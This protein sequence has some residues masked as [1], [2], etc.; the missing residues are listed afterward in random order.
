[1]V[2]KTC[3]KC[4][5]SYPCTSDYFHK[6]KEHKYGYKNI[7]KSCVSLYMQKYKIENPKPSDY[8]LDYITKYRDSLKGSISHKLSCTKR[9]YKFQ[10]NLASNNRLTLTTNQ[11]M[12]ICDKFNWCC[13]YCGKPLSKPTISMVERFS[14]GYNLEY[15]NVVCSCHECNKLKL[16]KTSHT[17]FDQ[18]YTNYKHF[19]FDRFDAI[20]AHIKKE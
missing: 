12:S 13:A 16:S 10:N 6:S 2:Y 8:K 5:I 1:M 4:N 20:L 3:S 14:H 18:W 11:F 15:H 17:S 19:D 9:S 7:C